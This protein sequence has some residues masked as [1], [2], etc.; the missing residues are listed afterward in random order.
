MLLRTLCAFFTLLLV[1]CANF[2]P[3]LK[4]NAQVD[5]A[6]AYVY[7]RFS[8]NS[9]TLRMGVE[10]AGPKLYLF[11]FQDKDQIT[12]LAVT[13]GTYQLSRFVYAETD[14]TMKGETAIVQSTLTRSMTLEA[15]KAYYVGDFTGEGTFNGIRMRWQV[16]GIDNRFAA[17]TAEMQ[18]KYPQ[19]AQLPTQQMRGI[20]LYMT[21]H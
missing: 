15:G 16:T 9:H 8:S 6:K 1:S 19:F 20:A 12:M 14:G 17:T 2:V 4:P 21:A 10:L 3:P 13:P 18:Q 7:G 11:E 5:P